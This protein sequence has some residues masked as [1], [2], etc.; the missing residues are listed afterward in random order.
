[1][2]R[3]RKKKSATP[4]EPEWYYERSFQKDG[5][6]WERFWCPFC[7]KVSW[8]T[9]VLAEKKVIEMK[10]CPNIKKPYMLDAYPC[11]QNLGFHVGHNYIL[12]RPTLCV[13]EH[14]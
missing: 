1:L 13:G 11:P 14:K 2:G 9:K 7:R 3:K 4:K 8:R 10:S 5:A 12:G 6:D